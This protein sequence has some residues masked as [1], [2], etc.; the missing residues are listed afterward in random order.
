VVREARIPDLRLV[1][2]DRNVGLARSVVEGVTQVC[3]SHGR[4]IVVEDDLVL[5]TTFLAYMNEALERFRDDER[6]LHVGGY[7]FPVEL[8]CPH[9]SVF[10]PFTSSWGWGT[11]SRAWRHY[12]P[13]AS[14]YAALERDRAARR[15]FDLDGSKAFFEMLRAARAGRLD[16]WGIRWYLSVF[17]RG[18]LSIYPRRSLV[19]NEG[20]GEDA[21]HTKSASCICRA[22]E[23]DFVV[24]TFPGAPTVDAE[25]LRRIARLF[26]SEVPLEKRLRARWREF[27]HRLLGREA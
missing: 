14:A 26:R 2:R 25:A 8:G 4:A 18:G 11:W 21:T 5:S 27:R 3:D 1:E 6:I 15:R 12:D 23:S 19:R 9:D 13:T 16:S 22:E 17:A 20:F 24:R 10:L 7:M